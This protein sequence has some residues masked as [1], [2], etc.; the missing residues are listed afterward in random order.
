MDCRDTMQTWRTDEALGDPK[1]AEGLV[2]GSRVLSCV[3]TS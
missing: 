1:I 2:D 3:G